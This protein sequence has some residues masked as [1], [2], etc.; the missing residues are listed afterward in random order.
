[1]NT[2]L[3]AVGAGVASLAYGAFLTWQILRKPMGDDKMQSIQKA[4]QEGA[5]AYL[6]RQN[7]TVLVVGLVAVV[8]LYFLLGQTTAIGFL[9][10]AVASAAAGYIGMM[11]AVRTNSRVAEEAKNGL[12]S[13]FSL[14]FRG[15]AVTGFF[16]VGLALLSVTLFYW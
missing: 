2:L 16:V 14:G 13:A 3:L 11:V 8:A 6:K 1:M 10:G 15:G 12:A 4:I 9:V 7:Q 5:E